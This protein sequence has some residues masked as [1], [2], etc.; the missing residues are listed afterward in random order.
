MADKSISQQTLTTTA[1]TGTLIPVTKDGSTYR[2]PLLHLFN[3]YSTEPLVSHDSP[4]GFNVA[5]GISIASGINVTGNSNLGTGYLDTTTVS[6]RFYVYGDSSLGGNVGISSNLFVTGI[7]T[8]NQAVINNTLRV[9]GTADITGNGTFRNQLGVFGATNLHSSVNLGTAASTNNFSGNCVFPQGIRP[10]NITGTGPIL[11]QSTLRIMGNS[12]LEGSLNV[13]GNTTLGLT[14]S[15]I[16]TITGP[17]SVGAESVFAGNME[18][19]ADLNIGE[20]LTVYGNSIFGDS[21][22]DYAYFNAVGYFAQPV[23]S[24]NGFFVNNGIY[25]TGVFIHGGNHFY[26]S[27]DIYVGKR[28]VVSGDCFLGNGLEDQTYVRGNSYFGNDVVVSGDVRVDGQLRANYN[29][30]CKFDTTIY[31]ISSIAWSGTPG[32]SGETTAVLEGTSNRLNAG[33]IIT[34]VSGNPSTTQG[35]FKLTYS[36]GMTIRY[37]QSNNPTGTAYVTS[38]AKINCSLKKGAGVTGIGINGVGDY[39]VYFDAPMNDSQYGV[40]ITATSGVIGSVHPLHSTAQAVASCRIAI[41]N[42]NNVPTAPNACY[43]KCE[44]YEW[45]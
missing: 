20:N 23:Y 11:G 5:G 32:V 3:Y 31:T 19:S 21:V 33:N 37:L 34:I 26:N 44:G 1:N 4:V 39:T 41:V 15:E 38:S 7:S 17:L 8:L 35:N 43:V 10:A 12:T 22:A 40:F 29:K 24:L 36:N 28:L 13:Y 2:L 18:A 16:V 45:D 9:S 27:G 30:F 42:Y 25:S 6:G 14:S